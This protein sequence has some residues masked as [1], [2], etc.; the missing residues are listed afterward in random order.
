MP[1]LLLKFI[2]VTDAIVSFFWGWIGAGIGKQVV[3][4]I[5]KIFL[6]LLQVIAHVPILIAEVC[7]LKPAVELPEIRCLVV[8][9]SV[10]CQQK[11]I[12]AVSI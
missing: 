5:Q 3:H 8:N 7:I 10:N 2:L 11:F 4:S 1:K 9:I 12:H 6:I